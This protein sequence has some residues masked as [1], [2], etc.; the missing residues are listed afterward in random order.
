MLPF[1]NT[2]NDPDQEY[3]SEGITDRI[4]T[5]LS[6]VAALSVVAR[7]TA[8]TFKGRAIDVAETAQRM[9][10]T[11]VVEGSVRKSRNRIR[12]NALLV[13]GARGPRKDVI[14]RLTGGRRFRAF[15]L[16]LGR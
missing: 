11:H 15:G 13:G 14:S 10:L 7:S 6:K 2:S 1:A 16:G 9:N 8:F 12:I 3:F 5:D 4:V